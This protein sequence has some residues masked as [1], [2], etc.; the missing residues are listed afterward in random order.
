MRIDSIPS[1]ENWTGRRTSAQRATGR[2]KR[3]P[4]MKPWKLPRRH[5]PLDARAA[6]GWGSR[7]APRRSP[8][9][10][11]RR[12]GGRQR[13]C[14][15]RSSCARP[16]CARVVDVDFGDSRGRPADEVRRGPDRRRRA[17]DASGVTPIGVRVWRRSRAG[18][19]RAAAAVPR[20]RR[21]PRAREPT[22]L[23][24]GPP[25]ATAWSVPWASAKMVEPSVLT[26]S[27]SSTPSP[28]C[29]SSSS[30]ATAGAAVVARCCRR[31]R[32]RPHDTL[33]GRGLSGSGQRD[34]RRLRI[35]VSHLQ[36]PLGVRDERGAGVEPVQSHLHR[37][38]CLECLRACRPEKHHPYHCSD[39]QL[40]HGA[41][42][43]P[44]TRRRNPSLE[45][46]S[47]CGFQPRSA[48]GVVGQRFSS[49][50]VG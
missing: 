4:V 26:M 13:T 30:S 46:A 3:W 21:E 50:T 16:S 15:R 20:N 8:S 22:S 48:I 11:S 14:L 17:G 2:V 44:L 1:P 39:E 7:A 6:A 36:V 31:C 40:R 28:G 49:V 41:R 27:G 9:A 37:G 45:A 47:L 23:G 32:R 29:W 19:C 34:D 25:A 35:P 38:R 10:R 5:P 33:A 12:P 18:G 24:A 43:P 42:V